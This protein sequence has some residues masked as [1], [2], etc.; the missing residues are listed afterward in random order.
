[1]EYAFQH[2]AHAEIGGFG[3]RPHRVVERAT[4]DTIAYCGRVDN[5]VKLHFVKPISHQRL[6][7]LVAELEYVR[8]Q[9]E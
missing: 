3:T 1:M 7:V 4:G 6:V 9:P 5:E 8:L 2:T